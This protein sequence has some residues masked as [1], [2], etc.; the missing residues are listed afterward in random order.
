[1]SDVVLVYE[2][3]KLK[4]VG[5]VPYCNHSIVTNVTVLPNNFVPRARGLHKNPEQLRVYVRVLV[6]Q[7]NSLKLLLFRFS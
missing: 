7:E 4:D 5:L 2:I 6:T 1:M 3:W